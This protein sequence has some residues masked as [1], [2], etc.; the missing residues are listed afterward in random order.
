MVVDLLGSERNCEESVSLMWSLIFI[1]CLQ[2]LLV[3]LTANTNVKSNHSTL[4]FYGNP[5][6]KKAILFSGVFFKDPPGGVE[7][8]IQLSIAL[9]KA[10]SNSSAIYVTENSYN[11]KWEEM[12]GPHLIRN[13]KSMASLKPGDLFIINEGVL[14][15]EGVPRGVHVFVYILASYLGCQQ[16]QIRYISHNQRLSHFQGIRLPNERI[17]HPYLSERIVEMAVH[18]AGL[19]HD[20]SI[21]YAR[22]LLKDVKKNLVLIDSDVPERVKR[23]ISKAAENLGAKSVFLSELSYSAIIEMY[24]QAKIIVDWCMR[25][26]ERCPLEASLFGTAVVSNLCDTGKEFADFPVPGRYLLPGPILGSG[27]NPNENSEEDPELTANFTLIFKHVFDDYW[28]TVPDF[29]PLRRSVLGHN[30]MSMYKEGVRFLSSVYVDERKS[31][32]DAFSEGFVPIMPGG[33]KSC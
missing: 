18:R 25:G 24:E 33:C 15:P 5:N 13:V 21:S 1:L 11:K 14:C 28:E 7:A 8:I 2:F 16:P 20:G 9:N 10:T 31:V 22:S 3:Q 32:S 26:S 12:Y 27:E 4:G 6:P 19:Q 29:E 30:A 23:S 17:I